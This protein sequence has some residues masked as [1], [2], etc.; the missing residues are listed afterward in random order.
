[1]YTVYSSTIRQSLAVIKSL[2][3]LFWKNNNTQEIMKNQLSSV[4]WMYLPTFFYKK[5]Y[6]K[7]YRFG[8][9]FLNNFNLANF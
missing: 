8:N 4:Q 3:F 7:K 1:M 5:L 9:L 6:Y 2:H